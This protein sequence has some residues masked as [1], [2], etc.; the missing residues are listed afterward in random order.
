MDALD[1]AC[2]RLVRGCAAVEE[3]NAVLVVSN[4]ETR[5]LGELVFK[6]ASRITSRICHV[7][8]PSLTM[9]GQEPPGDVAEA[10][11]KSDVVFGL[12]RY[13]MAHSKA[14]LRASQAGARY[15][16]LP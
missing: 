12:T 13:S 11:L 9:H 8:I 6:G 1:Q 5:D 16:S 2:E 4:P 15:L 14:R 7:T 10:M 3:R